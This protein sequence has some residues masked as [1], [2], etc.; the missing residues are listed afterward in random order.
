MFVWFL[1]FALKVIHPLQGV[2]LLRQRWVRRGGGGPPKPG[3]HILSRSDIFLDT[4][5]RCDF[6]HQKA[7]LGTKDTRWDALRKATA[8]GLIKGARERR[9]RQNCGML[10]ARIVI[11]WVSLKAIPGKHRALHL[12]SMYCVQSLLSEVSWCIIGYCLMVL[13]NTCHVAAD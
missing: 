1:D 4:P 5:N 11:F 3:K 10:A 9:R 8:D 6:I 7:V 13:K 12:S 2:N